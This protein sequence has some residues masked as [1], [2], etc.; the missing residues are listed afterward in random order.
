MSF[1]KFTNDNIV[2][3]N[4][5]L[6]HLIKICLICL[7]LGP[8]KPEINF[9]NNK[10]GS[11]DVSYTPKVGGDYKIH[12]KYD[13]RD[14]IGSPFSCRI[15]GDTKTHQ[16]FV[17]KV[18]VGGHN[19]TAGK[20]KEKNFVLID[21]KESGITGGINFAMEGPSKPE[22]NFINNKDMTITV[23]FTPDTP[24]DYRLHLKFQD[25]HLPGSP[26][27]ITIS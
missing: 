26:Y 18:K 17:D 13:N 22:V 15:S 23:E 24:G 6:F 21:L 20:A 16:R 25:L 12:V 1:T 2:L 3:D 27:P 8:S 7:F 14:I 5:A 10:D 19:L 9:N 4:R 11:V